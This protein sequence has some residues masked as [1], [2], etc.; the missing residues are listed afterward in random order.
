MLIWQSKLFK[1]IEPWGSGERISTGLKALYM[2]YPS[3]MP[4]T[5]DGP[6]SITRSNP[7]GPLASLRVTVEAPIT[8]G[9]AGKAPNCRAQGLGS[10]AEHMLCMNEAQ[11]EVERRDTDS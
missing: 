3:L 4:G 10:E 8:S 9:E 7:G 11:R 6:Q 5:T 1:Q 2:A